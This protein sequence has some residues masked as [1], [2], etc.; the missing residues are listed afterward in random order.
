MPNPALLAIRQRAEQENY[1]GE[2]ITSMMEAMRSERLSGQAWHIVRSTLR[3][4]I[5]DTRT[6]VGRLAVVESALEERD[7]RIV[8]LV[9]IINARIAVDADKA[10]LLQEYLAVLA[11][12]L[13]RAA[14]AAQEEVICKNG[15]ES[16]AAKDGPF[17]PVPCAGCGAPA[18]PVGW[19]LENPN[20]TTVITAGA[21][22]ARGT[23]TP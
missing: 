5:T 10:D 14:E 17:W 23:G 15:H 18:A 9:V 11:P 3:A 16:R 22:A 12:G 4:L 1:V 7:A 8:R 20:G 6:I 19:W 21:A 13:I 2:L